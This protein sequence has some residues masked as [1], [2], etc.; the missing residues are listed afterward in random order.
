MKKLIFAALLLA[1]CTKEQQDAPFPLH[2]W[3]KVYDADQLHYRV[4]TGLYTSRLTDTSFKYP[5]YTLSRFPSDGFVY[6][7]KDADSVVWQIHSSNLTDLGV[8]K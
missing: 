8:K 3:V 6:N 2:H 7:V 1:A 4:A 5:A